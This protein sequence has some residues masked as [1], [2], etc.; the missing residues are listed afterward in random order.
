MRNLFL[1]IWRHHFIF[2]FLLMEAV[3]TVLIIRN[4]NYHFSAYLNSSGALTGSIYAGFNAIAEYFS[5]KEVN[6]QLSTENARLRAKTKY[7]FSVYNRGLFRIGKNVYRQQYLYLEGKVVNNSINRRNNYF[8]LSIGSEQGVKPGMGVISPDGIAGV[9][10]DVSAGYS[11]V[12][13]VLHKNTRVSVKIRKNNYFG[14]MVWDGTD[15]RKATLL[16]VPK[17]VELTRGDTVITSG[18]STLYPEGI[19]AGTIGSFTKDQ[20]DNFYVITLNL[21]TD[22][23]KMDFAYVVVNLYGVEQQELEN[24]SDND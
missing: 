8:T 22:F 23:G 5:L 7:S 20:E 19:V 2:L 3:C 15:Y 24:R 21:S 12:M 13:S 10:K 16:D 1:F 18:F 17:H 11:T 6:E 9:I 4:N 14:T